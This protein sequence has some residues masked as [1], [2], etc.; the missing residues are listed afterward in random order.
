[1]KR[2][3]GILALLLAFLFPL[4]P[5]S[6][7]STEA[8]IQREPTGAFVPVVPV[9]DASTSSESVSNDLSQADAST[10]GFLSEGEQ[11]PLSP[12][13]SQE[14]SAESDEV[15]IESNDPFFSSSGSWGQAYD[16]L[17]WLKRVRAPEAWSLARGAGVTVAVI[18]TGLDFNH[19]DIAANAWYNKAELNG[20]PGVDDDGNGY[21]DDIKGWDFQNGDN[22]P[23]DDNGHGTH[24]AGIIGAVSD[25]LQGIA[26][27]A[28]DSKILSVK[29]LDASGRGY[30]QNVISGIY[31][32]VN[33]GAQVINMSLG[34]LKAALPKSLRTAFEN[35]VNY[36]VSKGTVVAVAAGNSNANVANYYP[37][38]IPSAITV[39]AIEP[40]T[41]NR[42]WFSNFG[43]L[44]DLVAPGV[45]VLSLRAGGTNFGSSS[46]VDPN[47]ARASGTSMASPIV[48]GV[49][50]LLK[51]Q[52]PTL[53]PSSLY[54][55]LKFSA[56]D[57][58]A[59][60]FDIYYGYGLVDAYKAITTDYYATGQVKSEWVPNADGSGFTR[61]DY[62]SK[63]RLI[64]DIEEPVFEAPRLLPSPSFLVGNW[65]LISAFSSESEKED[66]PPSL[67]EKQRKKTHPFLHLPSDFSSRTQEGG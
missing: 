52:D 55:R 9:T 64:T 43:K 54:Q 49:A 10:T 22:N 47:Y 67:S 11:G 4:A 65:Y 50:A 26:G 3:Q 51:S 28:P 62:D 17:Y 27:V 44:L 13:D 20:L 63:G 57:L 40:V 23:Q 14:S 16:D 45:D 59:A 58:G 32:A 5:V 2:F 38:G 39:G 21:V 19:I 18:D 42:A 46:V 41:D 56:T 31:Y 35:A 36:A 34:V 1:M 61:R 8:L 37:S 25:N 24:V 30:V 33:L 60:G 7:A 48:A 29:V 12:P 66:E 6:F 53:T 15:E